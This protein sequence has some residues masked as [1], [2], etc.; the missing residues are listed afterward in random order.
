MKSNE[1][2]QYGMES[3]TSTVTNHREVKSRANVHPYLLTCKT[4]EVS[5]PVSDRLRESTPITG[6]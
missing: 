2:N 4:S 3:N 5:D 6:K 1:I